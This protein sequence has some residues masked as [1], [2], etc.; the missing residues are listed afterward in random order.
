M[1][2]SEY[3]KMFLTQDQQN[4]IAAI[5]AAAEK[6]GDWASA[7]N[8]AEAIRNSAGYSGGTNGAGYSAYQAPQEKNDN[9]ELLE[10]LKQMQAANTSANLANLASAY[11]INRNNLEAQ[12]KALPEMFAQSRNDAAAQDA[13]AR[14]NFDERAVANGLSNGASGQAELSRESAYRNNIAT[15]NATEGKS[16]SDIE[17]AKNNLQAEYENAIAQAKAKGDSQLAESLYNEMVRQEEKAT[18][19]AQYAQ[20]LA[21]KAGIK[22]A[23]TLANIRSL[24]DLAKLGVSSSGTLVGNGTDTNTGNGTL[25]TAQIKLLQTYYGVTADGI[26]GPNSS[27]AAGGLTADEAWAEYQSARK[28]YYDDRD[29]QSTNYNEV[30]TKANEILN[31]KGREAAMSYVREAYTTGAIDLSSYSKI[32]NSIRK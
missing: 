3:D 18:S 30:A 16:N 10:Y 17:L 22:D 14:K 19:D 12:Q 28:N 24:D 1:A 32:Y 7:H 11:Q 26:W 6:S 2:V 25:S 13:I 29:A 20:S 21:I 15:I 4:Q 9:S 8:A 5:T 27:K 23:A 31:T